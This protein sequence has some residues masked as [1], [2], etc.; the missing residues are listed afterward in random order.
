[1]IS[2]RRRS[3]RDEVYASYESRNEDA[4]QLCKQAKEHMQPD[5]QK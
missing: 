3:D 2:E 1:V 4:V 5:G